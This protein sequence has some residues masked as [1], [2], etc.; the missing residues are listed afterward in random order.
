[1]NQPNEPE[2]DEECQLEDEEEESGDEEDLGKYDLTDFTDAKISINL[3]KFGQKSEEKN[4][5]GSIC[6]SE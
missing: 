6:S 1:V 3:N 4:E 5:S 2:R